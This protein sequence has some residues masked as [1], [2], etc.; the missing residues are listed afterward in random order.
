MTM[1]QFL[2]S[3]RHGE[4]PFA[5]LLRLRA[6]AGISRRALARQAVLSPSTVARVEAGRGNSSTEFLTCHALGV[7]L[8][9]SPR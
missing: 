5:I 2:D 1:N 8:A 4:A 3:V 9:R 7:L 6:E